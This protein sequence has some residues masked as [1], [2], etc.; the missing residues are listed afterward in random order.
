[1]STFQ[2][3]FSQSPAERKRYVLDYTLFLAPGEGIVSIATAISPIDMTSPFVID[4]MA[5]LPPDVVGGPT[6][7]AAYF[8]S[9][10]NNTEVYEVQFLATTTLGQILED[11]VQYTLRENL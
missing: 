10:G 6:I 3:V 9:G 8:A 5:L 11:V 7:G 4:G 1:M 2:A